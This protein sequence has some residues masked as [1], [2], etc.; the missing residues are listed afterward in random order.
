VED[1]DV[2]MGCTFYSL[3]ATIGG[4]IYSNVEVSI[5]NSRFANNTAENGDGNDVYISIDS[6]F[7]NNPANVQGT[8]SLSLLPGQFRT[9]TVCDFYIIRMLACMCVIVISR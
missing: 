2:F 5:K 3:E 1:K 8:C 7:Y 4:A 9:P 6:Y